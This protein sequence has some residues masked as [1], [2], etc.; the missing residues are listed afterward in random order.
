MFSVGRRE[1][2]RTHDVERL[3]RVGAT[4][5]VVEIHSV[6]D[7]LFACVGVQVELIADGR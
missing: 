1:V 5:L 6:D 4:A 3:L 7:G 2:G